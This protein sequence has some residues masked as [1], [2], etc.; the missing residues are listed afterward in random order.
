ME[1]SR[2]RHEKQLRF[3][4]ALWWAEHDEHQ[5]KTLWC[6]VREGTMDFTELTRHEKDLL[7]D[8]K[9]GHL[10]ERIQKILQ[11]RQCAQTIP[12]YA[13]AGA[14]VCSRLPAYGYPHCAEQPV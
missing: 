7:E 1:N 8:Y 4:D 10:A 5:G 11:E 6:R 13:G 9:N 3:T 14:C 2:E 12:K